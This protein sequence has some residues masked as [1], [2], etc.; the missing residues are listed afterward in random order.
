M[1]D[2]KEALGDWFPLVENSIPESLWKTIGTQIAKDLRVLQPPEQNI[3]RAFQLTKPRDVKVVILGQDPYPYGEADGLAF[4]STRV[5][6]PYSLQIIYTELE[7]EGYG[8]RMVASLDDWAKQGVLLLN[9]QL[10]TVYGQRD[11][12]GRIGWQQFTGYILSLIALH[13]EN[14]VY[15]IWGSYAREL[16]ETAIG[17]RRKVDEPLNNKLLYGAHPSAQ[18]HGYAYLGCNHFRLCNEY[19]EQHLIKPIEWNPSTLMK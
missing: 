2:L 10:T 18:Q 19:L 11:A 17:W 6:I 4:S 9:T 14:V 7:R 12:H 13:R 15:M 1:I 16:I 5:P 8:M 3:F